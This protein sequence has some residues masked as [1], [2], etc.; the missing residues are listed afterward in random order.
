[1][2]FFF[3]CPNQDNPVIV[4]EIKTGR[5][6]IFD[7]RRKWTRVGILFFDSVVVL[8]YYMEEGTRFKEK[9]S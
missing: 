5:D 1:M 7:Q 9:R 3:I 4:E 2:L 6:F 8:A